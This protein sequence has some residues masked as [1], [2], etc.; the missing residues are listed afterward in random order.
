MSNYYVSDSDLTS[1]ANAIRTKGGTSAPL[2]FP[3]GFVS[4]VQAIPQGG[5]S[6]YPVEDNDVMFYDYD[7]TPLYSYSA[8][9]FLALSAM[10]DNPDRTAEGLTADGWTHTLAEAQAYVRKYGILD[11]GQLYHPTDNLLHFFI[12]V[13]D[14]L[15]DVDKVFS[16]RIG[17]TGTDTYI[18]WGDGNTTPISS[19]TSLA[20]EHTYSAAGAYEVVVHGTEFYFPSSNNVTG[21]GN[22]HPALEMI[23]K[24]FLTKTNKLPDSAFKECS[25]LESIILDNELTTAI[26]DYIF[27]NCYRLKAVIFSPTYS[28]QKANPPSARTFYTCRNLTVIVLPKTVSSS[29]LVKE[30]CWYCDSLKRFC[31]PENAIGIGDNAFNECRAL[32]DVVI[33]QTSTYIGKNAFLYCKNLKK[34][35]LGN[36]ESLSDQAICL[37]NNSFEKITIPASMTSIG[38]NAFNSRLRTITMLPETP[39]TIQSSTFSNLTALAKIIVPAGKL[40]AYQTATNWANYASYMEEATA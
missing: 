17:A 36:T 34:I 1:V 29:R 28:L 12:E 10:P 5:G 31:C 21:K 23:K 40:E 32:S 11:I 30:F 9:D 33:P 15:D 19:T 6:S 26:N 25:S 14:C 24:A 39:P 3:S 35:Q 8:T 4:A 18:D 16:L 7:G 13:P 38:K 22:L 37:D 27:Q 2:A 20:Y